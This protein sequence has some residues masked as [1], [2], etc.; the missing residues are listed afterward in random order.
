MT[1][2]Y[3][4]PSYTDTD[5][6]IDAIAF[7]A[8]AGRGI[9]QTLVPIANGD[10]RRT[11]NGTLVDLTRS[12]NRKYKSTINCTDSTAPALDGIWRGKIVTVSC[13]A[14]LTRSAETASVRTEVAGSEVVLSNGDI[15]YCPQLQMML[16]DYSCDFDEW[17]GTV[18]WSLEL[19]EV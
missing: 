12:T 17:A 19:E 13:V 7:P 15:S 9:K 3:D 16:I 5:L 6:V 8:A 2:K 4:T 14:R 18:N 11:I 1:N 10:M